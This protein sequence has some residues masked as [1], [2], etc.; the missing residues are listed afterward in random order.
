MSRPRLHTRGT[1]G[2]CAA[3]LMLAATL[4][5]CGQP[6]DDGLSEVAKRGKDVAISNG[7]A[8]CH[9]AKGQGGVGPSWVDLAGSEVELD[10][11]TTVTA[12]DAYLVRSILEP[13]AEIVEG[14]TILM[15]PNVLNESQATD[16]VA[17]IKELTSDEA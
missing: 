1:I 5:G 15:P 8:S 11:G 12:D 4:A 9:G 14:Y 3:T 17:Y 13:D 2:L 16:V 10:D 6:G 7:C